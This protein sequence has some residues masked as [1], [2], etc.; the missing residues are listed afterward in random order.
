VAVKTTF[1]DVVIVL[2]LVDFDFAYEVY[3]I[4]V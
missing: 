1:F 3:P 4:M 2:V